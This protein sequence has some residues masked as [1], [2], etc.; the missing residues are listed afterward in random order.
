M[1]SFCLV[2]K[3]LNKHNNL[4]HDDCSSVRTC[5][6]TKRTSYH[7]L[8]LDPGDAA[9]RAPGGQKDCCRPASTADKRTE[10]LLQK[11]QQFAVSSEHWISF[12][13]T[14][15]AA[16]YLYWVHSPL[17]A[18]APSRTWLRVQDS[19]LVKKQPPQIP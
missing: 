4:V 5:S 11:T 15:T 1:K 12:Y 7:D 2:N 3:L 6:D 17:P 16:W 8:R 14:S 19:V 10:A 18:W 9:Q 13:T